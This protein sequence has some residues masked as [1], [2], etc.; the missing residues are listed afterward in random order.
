VLTFG[1]GMNFSP[2]PRRV[3]AI[4][5]RMFPVVRSWNARFVMRGK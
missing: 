3:L 2:S 1:V 4:G 5:G